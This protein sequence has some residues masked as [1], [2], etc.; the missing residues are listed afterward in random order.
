MKK[1]SLR[2]VGVKNLRN[3]MCTTDYDE[4]DFY[5]DETRKSRKEHICSECN[6]TIKKGDI[7]RYVFGVWE[8]QASTFRTC[9][10]CM[11]P[12]EWLREECN[13]FMHGGLEE[14]IHEHAEQYRKMFLYRWLI[15]I[16][17]Q[18]KKKKLT[19]R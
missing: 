15:G 17:R 11:V 19:G 9:H 1:N 3:D 6:G 16:R 14:E 18:W 2:N 12:Q 7:Y 13:G 5:H 10:N 4:A 8:G